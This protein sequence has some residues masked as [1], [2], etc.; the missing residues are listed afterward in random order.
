MNCNEAQ[1][2]FALV[3][4]LPDSHPQRIAFKAH[5]A[6][7]EECSEQFDV[8]EEAQ[9]L[10]HSIP[11]PV[12]EQQAERV[13]RNVMDRIYMESPW[14]LPEEAKVNRFSA[15]I[16]KHMSLWIAA[17]LAIFLCSFLYMAMFKPE[18]SEAE[19]SN[20]MTTGILETGVAGST[21]SSSG[22]YKYNIPQADQ[23]SIIE[24]FVVSMSPA[25]PQYWMA[26]S[27]LAIGMALFSLGRMH[28]STNKRKQGVR[29]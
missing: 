17:F 24:P 9:I 14:L 21:S 6:G 1:E 23:G 4:D 10:L 13:N 29:A 12:T 16:R 18:V 27:L 8:W 26:L 2:L 15:V 22:L 3:W 25:Y 20:A 19:K 7:C 5:L 28:R 11:V